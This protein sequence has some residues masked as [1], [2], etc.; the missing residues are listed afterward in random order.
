MK[1]VCM[2]SFLASGH[3]RSSVHQKHAKLFLVTIATGSTMLFSSAGQGIPTSNAPAATQLP[4][5]SA[6]TNY[7]VVKRERDQCLWQRVSNDTGT[8]GLG[9]QASYRTNFYVELQTG[10]S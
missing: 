7:S 5:L 2:K 8:N 6:E 4:A 1:I 3:S 10:M 9:G